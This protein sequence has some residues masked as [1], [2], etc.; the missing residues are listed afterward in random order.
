MAE[1]RM[2]STTIWQ[3]E[4]IGT[5]PMFDRLVWLALITCVDDQGRMINNPVLILAHGFPYDRE[6]TPEN[7]EA[8]IYKFSEAG[9]II[10]YISGKRSYIQVVKWWDY[11]N[12]SWPQASKYPAP[13]GWIDRIKMHMAGTSVRIENM[14][15]CGGFEGDAIPI[16]Y[17][18]NPIGIQY[19]D[20]LVK[21]SIDENR[22]DYYAAPSENSE[23]KSGSGGIFTLY[24]ETF[25]NFPPGIII[26]ELKEYEN[27]HPIEHLRRAFQITA[28]QGKRNWAYP[29]RILDRWEVDGYDG[30]SWIKTKQAMIDDGYHNVTNERLAKQNTL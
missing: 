6:L 25:G 12:L 16:Q 21:S 5:L 19:P 18:D 26:D 15:K 11:Q 20:R 29:R 17:K 30:D 13:E 7:I 14:D 27:K 1:K 3:D 10:V 24:E 2:I 9:K 8:A 22:I 4:F 28:E 23:D